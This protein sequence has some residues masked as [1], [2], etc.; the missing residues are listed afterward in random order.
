MKITKFT[1]SNQSTSLHVSINSNNS[2]D[3]YAFSV[4]YLRVFSPE[5]TSKAKSA[6]PQ[7][8]HKKN[9]SLTH[10]ESLGK[11]G[12]RFTFNDGFQDIFNSEYLLDLAKGYDERWAEYIAQTNNAGHSR[13]MSIDITQ[14]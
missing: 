5:E 12:Y 4:E 6:I 14:L 2:N 7:V 13:E 9:T 8:F 10:V 1:L 11:H 3:E